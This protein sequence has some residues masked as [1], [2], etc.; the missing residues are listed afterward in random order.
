MCLSHEYTA[1]IALKAG[2]RKHSN[3]P[4]LPLLY[5]YRSQRADVLLGF[6]AR[7]LQS[8]H[9][10]WA[11]SGL[12]WT[13]YSNM[14][15]VHQLFDEFNWHHLHDSKQGLCWSLS[16][17]SL[18]TKFREN[19]EYLPLPLVQ[20]D[21]LPLKYIFPIHLTPSHGSVVSGPG[22]T[23]DIPSKTHKYNTYS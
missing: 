14:F 11:N 10:D 7:S 5:P 17:V 16:V 18:A 21:C 8:C 2:I 3:H 4:I 20:S 13:S 1:Q 9:E 19:N 12:Y 23:I 15:S 22:Q 6:L